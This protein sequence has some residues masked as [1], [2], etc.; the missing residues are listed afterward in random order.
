MTNTSS[1]NDIKSVA[2]AAD[3]IFCGYAYTLDDSNIRVINLNRPT[4]ASLMRRSGEILETSMDDI[5]IQLMLSYWSRV[6]KYVE[7]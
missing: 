6:S 3:A 2:D 1:F 4:H 7:E 5:E